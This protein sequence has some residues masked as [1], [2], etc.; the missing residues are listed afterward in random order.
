LAQ[1]SL[2]CKWLATP[3]ILP[4]DPLSQNTQTYNWQAGLEYENS[5]LHAAS[6]G[7]TKF[8]IADKKIFTAPYWSKINPPQNT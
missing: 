7:R 6:L 4:V 3:G 8:S 1:D 5:E 2:K